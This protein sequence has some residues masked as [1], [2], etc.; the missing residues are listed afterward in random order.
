MRRLAVALVATVAT[1]A[2]T[3]CASSPE[4]VGSSGPAT[5]LGLAPD[6]LV[7][8]AMVQPDDGLAP[9]VEFIN[10]ATRTLDIA[11][12]QLDPDYEPLIQ[13]IR[14]AMDRGVDVR[15]LLSG[16]IYPTNAPNA[17]PEDV[18]TLRS[19]GIDARLSRP[20]FSFSHWK[21]LIA[22]GAT[23]QGKALIC[24][25]NL[26]AGYFGLDPNYP[27]EGDTRGM[28]V[29][30]VDP[31]DVRQIQAVF[32]ADWP[33]YSTWPPLDSQRLVWSPSDDTCDSVSCSIP[34]ELEPVGNS[35]NRLR[36]LI[37]SATSALDIYVQAFAYPSALL[38]PVLDACAR[39]VEV[40][41]V[42]NKGGINDEVLRSL[43]SCG[44][45][46]RWDAVDPT[47]D[48]RVMYIHTK[49]IIVDPGQPQQVAY[50]GSINPFLDESLQ[51]ERELGVFVTDPSSVDRLTSTFERDFAAGVTP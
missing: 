1:V 26:E 38:M 35:R 5:P 32:D 7:T 41:I 33:P 23:P 14:A 11:V 6:S 20:E 24:D 36:A 18:A 34:A 12:Y 19:L 50:V 2:L 8:L 15:I 9:V 31:V 46:V 30:D 13:A 10:S 48:G 47:N 42:G 21:V 27:D 40:K 22:D 45:Q 3:S 17:N 4:V 28:A 39:G 49:T 29:V 51:T 43:D 25:F 37:D 44:A 16:T